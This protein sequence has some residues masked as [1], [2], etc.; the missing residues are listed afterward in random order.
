NFWLV[1]DSKITAFEQINF[2]QRF[3]ESKLP[4]TE[5][6]ERIMREMIVIE[7]KTTYSLS[8]KTGW[9]IRGDHNNGWFVGYV[10]RDK[11]VYY[12]ATNV[13]P[14]VDFDMSQFPTARK[15]V[16]YQALEEMEI[17]N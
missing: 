16:T 14:E 3:Y 7:N 10:E 1:G 17:I 5:R 4:I 15:K 2:L 11:K 9:S 6:T 12:F 13:E 8:G